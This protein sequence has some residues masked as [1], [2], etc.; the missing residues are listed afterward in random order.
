[1]FHATRIVSHVACCLVTTLL[2]KYHVKKHIVAGQRRACGRDPP[3][4]KEKIKKESG[5]QNWTP[6][7][8]IKFVMI[9][10]P[11]NQAYQ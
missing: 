10:Q 5:A 9:F 4:K 1:M 8:K 7:S 3:E 2:Q 11:L 6:D